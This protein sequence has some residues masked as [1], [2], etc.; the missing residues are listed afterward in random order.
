[1]KVTVKQ[2]AELAVG[3]QGEGEEG[4]VNG[5]GL[6]DDLA[7]QMVGLAEGHAL[8]NQVIGQFGRQHR[9]VHHIIH[10]RDIDLERFDDPGGNRQGHT[11]GI[12]RVEEGFFVL[13]E[14]LVVRRRLPL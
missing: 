3:G 7:G 13:L 2:V 5:D 11:Q 12:D 10:T 6:P 4:L 8:F 9:T 1:M 14:I